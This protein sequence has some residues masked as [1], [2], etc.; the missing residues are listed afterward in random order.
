MPSVEAQYPV[1]KT[2]QMVSLARLLDT[3]LNS[4]RLAASTADFLATWISDL[5]FALLI[6]MRGESVL[7]DLLRI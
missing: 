2:S 5:R 4:F 3:L 1:V 6:L 7:T